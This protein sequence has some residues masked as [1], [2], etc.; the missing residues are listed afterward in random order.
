[1]RRG[2]VLGAVGLTVAAILMP[3]LGPVPGSPE[4]GQG[5]WT[6]SAQA[7]EPCSDRTL[8]GRWGLSFEGSLLAAIS[9]TTFA[10]GLASVVAVLDS[11]GAGSFTGAGTFNVAGV[12]G[13]QSGTGTYLVN[14][15]CSGTGTFDYGVWE[16]NLAFV[17]IGEGVNREVRFVNTSQPAVLHGRIRRL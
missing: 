6:S 5:R 9:G 3:V 17:I 12:S 8:A 16:M 4:G 10:P 1:M 11:D 7:Q 14:P 13:S 15:D 2:I